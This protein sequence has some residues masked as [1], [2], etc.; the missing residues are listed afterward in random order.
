MFAIGFLLTTRVGG[1][2]RGVVRAR[3]SSGR[4]GGTLGTERCSV[5]GVVG[6]NGALST[7]GRSRLGRI[8]SSSRCSGKCFS[9]AECWIDL[10]ASHSAAVTPARSHPKHPTKDYLAGGN[11]W[12]GGSPEGAR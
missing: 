8:I 3:L 11:D 2:R 6:A 7:R 1:D 9:Q 12:L 10:S 4:S 5:W